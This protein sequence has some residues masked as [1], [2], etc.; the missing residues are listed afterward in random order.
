MSF[1]FKVLCSSFVLALVHFPCTV[2]SANDDCEVC[3]GFLTKFQKLVDDENVEGEPDIRKRLKEVCNEARGKENRFCYYIGGTDDAATG[4]IQEVSKPCS[5]HMPPEKICSKLKKKDSQICE[6]RYDKKIDW[7]SVNFN[8]MRVKQL[9]K[10]LEE[11]GESCKGCIE[12]SEYIKR[13]K[14]LLPKY[15]PKEEL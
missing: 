9:K 6:L 4:L 7:K 3:I 12:K 14:D 10:I 1:Y 15:V 13:I 2:H 5:Y 11:W 8:K